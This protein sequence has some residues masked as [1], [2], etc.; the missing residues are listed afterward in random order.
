MVAV[1]CA[2][3][4]SWEALLALRLLEGVALAGLPAVATAYLREELHPS[5]HA[6]AAGLYVGGT[7]IGGMAGRLV[8]GP[9][10]EAGR[11]AVGAGR[12]GRPRPGLRAGRAPAA[13][14]LA[15]LRRRR[16]PAYAELASMARRALSDPALLALYAIGGCAIGAPGGGV[17][18]DRVPARGAALRPR[19]GRR[20]AWSSSSTP[21]ARVARSVSGRLADALG[22]RAVPPVGCAVAIAGAAADP[23][24]VAAGGGARAGAC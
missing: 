2:V 16:R 1:A 20:R 7:A 12:R 14:R 15:Q 19:A 6:R 23:A 17:Q 8:T 10:G 13:A 22:R 5:T 24:A 4:P 18:H 3:A 9:V 11:L 21:S